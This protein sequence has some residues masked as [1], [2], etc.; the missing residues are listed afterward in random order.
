MNKQVCLR[1]EDYNKLK[2]LAGIYS[3]K[4]LSFNQIVKQPIY[5]PTYQP[6]Y[7]PSYQPTYYPSIIFKIND[8]SVSS[9]S[10]SLSRPNYDG[11]I[12][13]LDEDRMDYHIIDIHDRKNSDGNNVSI[14]D[15]NV[16]FLEV[17]NT[18]QHNSI[19][20]NLG[21]FVP[22]NVYI[23]NK[24]NKDIYKL[25]ITRPCT[26]DNYDCKINSNICNLS[27]EVIN[28]NYHQ[29]MSDILDIQV[30]DNYFNNKT[31][32]LGTS[33]ITIGLKNV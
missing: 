28:I 17:I 20:N 2:N 16:T 8:N 7:Q 9:L 26:C 11:K 1:K 27:Y 21:Y 32:H 10:L 13:R 33:L 22:F 15:P 19:I 12:N 4:Y 3:P 30:I 18:M 5:Q 14:D 29:D 24:N 31:G 6:T 23:Y 25:A